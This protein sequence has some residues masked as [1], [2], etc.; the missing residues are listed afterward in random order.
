MDT[1]L[2]RRAR[3]EIQ[4]LFQDPLAALSPRRS[5]WQTLL[6]SLLLYRVGIRRIMARIEQALKP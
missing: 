4:Y 3:R 5:I 1:R 6:E 2:L